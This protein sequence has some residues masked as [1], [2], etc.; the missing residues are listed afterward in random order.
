MHHSKKSSH[1]RRTQMNHNNNPRTW[2]EQGILTETKMAYRNLSNH[3]TMHS[4]WLVSLVFCEWRK[5]FMLL[6]SQLHAHLPHP[7]THCIHSPF[8]DSH[9]VKRFLSQ[10]RNLMA[11]CGMH[12]EGAGALFLFI[13]AKARATL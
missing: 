7:L 9:R 12:A 4:L 1:L 10:V 13:P 5:E 8:T 3:T 6:Y 2:D 11:S